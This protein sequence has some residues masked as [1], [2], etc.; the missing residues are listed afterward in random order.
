MLP[1]MEMDFWHFDWSFR[2]VM[3]VAANVVKATSLQQ[4]K[5]EKAAEVW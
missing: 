5:R 3:L 4:R 1:T 2:C